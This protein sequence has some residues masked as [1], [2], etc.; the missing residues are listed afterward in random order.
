VGLLHPLRTPPFARLLTSYFVNELGDTVGALALAI[1]VY[2]ATGDPMA[3]T[4]LLV[5]S[6]FVPSLLAPGLTARVDQFPVGRTLALI[7][8]VE[9]ACFAVL[10]LLATSFWLPLVLVLALVDG[11]LALTARAL[12]RGAIA[13]VF[14]TGEPL[15]AANSL[16]N[17]GFATATIL[18]AVLAGV[19]IASFDVQLALVADAASFALVALLVLTCRGLP[20]AADRRQGSWE[21]L[22]EALGFVRRRPLLRALLAAQA[23]ALVLFTLI[24][25]IEVVY[26]KETLGA[27]SVGFGVLMGSWGVG[28]VLGSAVFAAARAQPVVTLVWAATAL[29]GAG[30]LGMGLVRDLAPAAAFSVLGGIG[31]GMQVVAVMTLLQ[32]ETPLELQTR[33]TG[34]LESLSAAMPGVGYLLGGVLTAATDPAKTYLVAGGGLLALVTVGLAVLVTPRRRRAAPS[35]GA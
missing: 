3:T 17:I 27:G 16:V 11:L 24:V 19:L 12:T 7:Y 34:L 14:G 13:H 10:A 26:A 31:N 30:Y 20:G 2:D 21:R 9:A 15:R 8:L 18:G 22:R 23:L 1:L 4:A 32:Q 33:V 25:P 6:R 35:G 5:A 29:V 28:M